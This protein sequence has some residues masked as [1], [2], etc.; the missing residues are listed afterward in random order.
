VTIYDL[1]TQEL[2]R[3]GKD[4]AN[5]VVLEAVMARIV[6]DDAF[7]RGIATQIMRKQCAQRIKKIRRRNAAHD[8]GKP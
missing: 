4:A 2:Q 1:I 7:F 5:A 3:V 6:S 8:E